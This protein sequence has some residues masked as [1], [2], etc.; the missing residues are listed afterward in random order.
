MVKLLLKLPFEFLEPNCVLVVSSMVGLLVVDQQKPCSVI[1][2]PISTIVPLT[3]ALF[4][5]I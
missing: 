5:V 3:V 4:V 2:S 1:P